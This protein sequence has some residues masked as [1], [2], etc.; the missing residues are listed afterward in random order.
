MKNIK[1]TIKSINDKL[2]KWAK[3]YYE[4]DKPSVS[5]AQYDA[6]YKELV[7][8]EKKHPQFILEDSITKRVGYLKNT[9]FEKVKHKFPML[10]LSNAFNK[11]D[12]IKFNKQIRDQLHTSNDIEYVLEYKID[13]LSISLIYEN[14]KLIKG[15]TRGD[16]V[17]GEDVTHNIL[18]IK[19]IPKE[20]KY[21]NYLEVRGE[22]FISN[23]T[24]KQLINEGHNFAN[25]RN[26]AAGT[27]RQ[28]DSNIAKER[29]LSSFIYSIPNP[30]E[31]NLNS[32]SES[33]K[34]LESNNFSINKNFIHCKNIDE[35]L[36]AID[37][38]TKKRDSQ[39]YEI[40]G[41][42]TKVN[43]IKL[44]EDI[45]Y[46]SKFPKYM[47]AYKFPEEVSQTQL[48]DIFPTIGRTG[49]VTYNAKLSPVRLAGTTVSAATLHNADYILENDINIG[50]VVNVKKAG[51]IIP[52]VLSVFK[53]KNNTKWNEATV[54][55]SCN[56]KL[57]RYDSEVDQYCVNPR[58]IDINIAKL[59]HFV[60]REAMDIE[61]LSIETIR[62]FYS[63]SL[64]TNFVSIYKL[65][66]HKEQILA[67]PG[68]KD[69]SVNNMLSAIEKS[70]TNDLSKFIFALGIR[71]VGKKNSRIL[72]KRFSSLSTI[73][74]TNE[75]S[76]MQ[77]RDLGPKAATSLISF[78][79]DEEN[80]KEIKE[81]LDLGLKLK[82]EEKMNS[83]IFEGKTFVIT[84]TLSKSRNEFENIIE[85]NSG[86]ISSSVTS[87]TSYVLV[88]E[89]PGSKLDKA[90]NLNI[91]IL[92]EE[93]F[94][95]LLG[96]KNE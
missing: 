73:M 9:K 65:S 69:K 91:P 64:L 24:F 30:I 85:L 47:I 41:I 36:N 3:E 25:P 11:D 6:L 31:H 40:D 12:L 81:L 86:N 80:K 23:S 58:C 72:S 71:H 96:G 8:L 7:E 66:N 82:E 22:I 15:I 51:E 88:G 78:F 59:N 19:D 35:V 34:F 79:K 61:G 39:D 38:L 94:K 62:T 27:I 37:K 16:G 21:K 20:I 43:N 89:N 52:K 67:M 50:D 14:G 70:K 45:G 53:K 10:S 1:D 32:H 29:K 63:E 48:L 60:S 74:D 5:D 28:L 42:V 76:I 83:K 18:T 49:R 90:K 13:G 33:L 93:Q 95:N 46:T 2:N 84:G 26:A 56:F 57:I 4:E 44:W 87:K 92:K 54:C 68:F 77:I 75:D 17:V 55:P